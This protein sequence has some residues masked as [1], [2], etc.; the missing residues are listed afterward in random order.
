MLNK[1]GK[2]LL[3]KTEVCKTRKEYFKKFTG[4][5]EKNGDMAISKIGLNIKKEQN[6]YRGKEDA[7][8]E[9]VRN[10]LIYL[11]NGKAGGID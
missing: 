8:K 2:L 7:I 10:V 6:R 11:K 9:E 5:G 4:Y 3:T 1:S